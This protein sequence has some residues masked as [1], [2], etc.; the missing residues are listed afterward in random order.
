MPLLSSVQASPVPSGKGDPGTKTSDQP[1]S[2]VANPTTGSSARSVTPPPPSGSHTTPSGSPKLTAAELMG[3]G[4]ELL[5]NQVTT[6]EDRA[7]IKAT[8]A[9]VNNV[10][11]EVVNSVK[12]AYRKYT[13]ALVK[14]NSAEPPTEI[15]ITA[16]LINEF[17]IG[18][19]GCMFRFTKEDVHGADAQYALD[20][21][22]EGHKVY[23]VLQ[24]KRME[25][26]LKDPAHTGRADVN[27]GTVDWLKENPGGIKQMTLVDN[28]VKAKRQKLNKDVRVIGGYI[29]FWAKGVT[30]VPIEAVFHAH[31]HHSGKSTVQEEVKREMT[32]ELLDVWEKDGKHF[33]DTMLEY[34]PA[35]IG[36]SGAA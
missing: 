24:M 2:A 25:F 1:A 12:T 35:T 21:E 10:C 18:D 27:R 14:S 13:T 34:D 8:R 3:T 20:I 16:D 11:H 22:V 31:E 33:V 29:V 6:A 23:A 28:T 30:F 9:N 36:A 4:S 32:K 17:I 5:E 19:G 15:S 26:K 7:R